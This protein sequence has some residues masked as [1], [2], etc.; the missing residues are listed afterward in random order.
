[1]HPP[2]EVHL[3]ITAPLDD[4]PAPAIGHVTVHQERL[5]VCP[6]SDPVVAVFGVL[7]IIHGRAIWAEWYQLVKQGMGKQRGM[8]SPKAERLPGTRTLGQPVYS[9][10]ALRS[11]SKFFSK[12]GALLVANCWA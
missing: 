8:C 10:Q 4:G 7:P 6:G 5:S 2:V 11:K 9:S 1:M 3:A 12:V